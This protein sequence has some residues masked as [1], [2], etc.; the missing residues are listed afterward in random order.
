MHRQVP[1]FQPKRKL[2][3][4]DLQSLSDAARAGRILPGF[5]IRVTT[6]PQGTV[7]ALARRNNGASF[8]DDTHPFQPFM[9]PYF[10]TGNPPA[11]QART[12]KIRRGFINEVIPQN[13]DEDFVVPAGKG[14]RDPDDTGGPSGSPQLFFVEVAL[15]PTTNSAK[16]ASA[17]IKQAEELPQSDYSDELPSKVHL[18]LF[19]IYTNSEAVTSVSKLQKTNANGALV[20]TNWDCK[21]THRQWLWS[22][23]GGEYGW[24]DW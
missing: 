6:S 17:T 18:P 19:Y 14:G 4:R 20:V 12:I 13:I 15:T 22:H 7:V 21:N 24:G 11:S 1:E 23:P 9:A 16:V 10:G 5:G 8:Q 3:A 2:Y